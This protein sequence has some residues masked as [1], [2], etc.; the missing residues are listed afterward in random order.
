VLVRD[1]ETEG[2]GVAVYV[3]YISRRPGIALDGFHQIAGAGQAGWA[4]RYDVDV[5]ILN[6]GRTWRLG[7]EPEYIAIWHSPT[8]GLERL[9]EWHDVFESHE[10]DDLELVFNAV[11]RIDEAGFYDALIEPV[12]GRGGPLYYAEFFDLAHGAVRDDVTTWFAERVRRNS[13]LTL[14]IV[15]DRVGRLGP[16]P[17]GF[18]FWQLPSYEPLE[19]IARELQD[20]DDAGVPIRLERAGLYAD[21]GHEIL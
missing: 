4:S 12:A 15:A 2:A 16:N 7:S 10:A 9:G 13:D 6:V 18:A 20:A 21:I 19:A 17:R 1:L 11:G 8:R 3:E 14:N 5:L